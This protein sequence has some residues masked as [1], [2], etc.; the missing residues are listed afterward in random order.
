M[1]GIAG[2]CSPPMVVTVPPAAAELASALDAIVN[3]WSLPNCT[4]DS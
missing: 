3:R 4:S 2:M 1:N